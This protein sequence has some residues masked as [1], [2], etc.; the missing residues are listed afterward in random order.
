MSGTITFPILSWITFLPI[1]GILIVLL[2]PSG[3][4]EKAQELSKTVI[5]WVSVGITF[6]QLVLAV[7]IIS[8]F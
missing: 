1:V 6:L 4:D 5:R 3:K 8:E 2:I 7:I